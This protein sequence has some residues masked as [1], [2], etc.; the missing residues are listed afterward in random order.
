MRHPELAVAEAAPARLA[1]A[2]AQ[3][4]RGGLRPLRVAFFSDALPERN[5]AGSY[6]HDLMGH[7]ETRIEA[8][9]MFQPAARARLPR[10][11]L[12][13]PGDAT[14][15]LLTPNVPKIWARFAALRP[16]VVVA[17]TPGPFG[18]LGLA[19]ARQQGCGFISGFHTQFEELSRLYWNPVSRRLAN[20]YLSATNG[21]ICR[22]SAT[23]MV[24]NP[25]LIETV[26]ALG[27]AQTDVMGT[28]LAPAFLQ[29][30]P[31][32]LSGALHRVLFAGRLAPEKNVDAIIAAAAEL[33]QVDFS[34]C[35]DGPL[36]QALRR[37]ARGLD[38][39]RFHGW[40]S[41]AALRHELDA[42]DL[43]LLPSA[44]ETFGT[45]ALEAMAR[46]RPALVAAGAGIHDWPQLRGG[47]FRLE[48][49]Q[50]VLEG[51]ETLRGLP[52]ARWRRVGRQARQAAEA[53]NAQTLR[54]WLAL[55]EQHARPRRGPR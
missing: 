40:L 17:I 43:L 34:I 50:S 7:L 28:P 23:V 22:H 25:R 41:R 3:T 45:I 44:L 27:A 6:Y 37:Q 14:Q 20:T 18:L 26:R 4:A 10:V 2:P 9:A 13:L 12:P 49:G 15:K 11:A 52:A 38:N 19:L 36:R 39:V 24:H 1:R 8:V 35:G 32:P 48:P 51:L 47:L 55:I 46:G 33:P 31:R 42:A 21:L 30:P 29:A 54:Q 16:D 5:G 53:L